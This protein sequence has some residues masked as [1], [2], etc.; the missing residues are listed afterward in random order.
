MANKI[1]DKSKIIKSLNQLFG[2]R[3]GNARAG[4]V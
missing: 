3:D 2:L 1:T 4:F